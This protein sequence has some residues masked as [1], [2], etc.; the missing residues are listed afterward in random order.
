MAFPEKAKFS[1]PTLDLEELF[2]LVSGQ[3]FKKFLRQINLWDL[4]KHSQNLHLVLFQKISKP[5]L[6]MDFWIENPLP[7]W[8]FHIFR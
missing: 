1:Q 5:F 7:P 6:Q 3:E 2:V 4:W 8:K